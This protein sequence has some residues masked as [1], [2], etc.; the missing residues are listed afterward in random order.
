MMEWV[1]SIL[2]VVI[3][4]WIYSSVLWIIAWERGYKVGY[5][6]CE[7]QRTLKGTR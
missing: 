1:W 2:A 4:G 3:L 7:K 6:V 5:Q